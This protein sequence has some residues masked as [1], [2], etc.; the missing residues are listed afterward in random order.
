[1]YF[2]LY[3]HYKKMGYICEGASKQSPD[4]KFYWAGTAPPGFE[5]LDPPMIS[6]YTPHPNLLN[7]K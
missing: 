4:P 2:I 1:M 3:S 6:V 7:T 5:I